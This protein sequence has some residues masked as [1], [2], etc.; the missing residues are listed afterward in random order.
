MCL[1]LSLKCTDYCGPSGK[2]RTLSIP[3]EL[4]AGA[5]EDNNKGDKGDHDNKVE[6]DILH[7]N[8]IALPV[9]P[10]H[11]IISLCSGWASSQ[12]CFQMVTRTNLVFRDNQ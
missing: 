9:F 8:Y 4:I 7:Q 10:N 6:K 3:E 12:F 1:M 11:P 2:L 5:P